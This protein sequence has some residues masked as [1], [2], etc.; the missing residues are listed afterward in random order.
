MA[1]KAKKRSVKKSLQKKE[2]KEKKAKTEDTKELNGILKSPLIVVGKLDLKNT[3]C[4]TLLVS[5]FKNKA[6]LDSVVS[7]IDSEFGSIISSCLKDGYFNGEKDE[8]KTLYKGNVKLSLLGLGEE[9]K[10]TLEAMTDSTACALRKLRDAGFKRIGIALD[11]FPLGKFNDEIGIE[12]LT[13]AAL[14]GL[15]NFIDFKTKNREKIKYVEKV[16]LFSDKY[17]RYK[18]VADNVK[19]IAEAVNKTRDL[20]NTPPNIANPDYV[21]NYCSEMARNSRLKCRVLNEN[22]LKKQNMNLMLAVAE[23]SA[24]KPRLVIMEYNGGGNKGPIVLVG[25]GI[26]FDSGGLNV[27]QHPYIQNMKDDKAGA[28]AVIHVIEAAAKLKLQ[29]NVV[30]IAGLCENMISGTSYRPDDVITS[31][32]GLTVE[33]KN[34]DAEGR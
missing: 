31:H 32:S 1:K 30:A 12:K 34:T 20:I 17:Q 21:A 13:I 4:D 5:L 19:I 18:V 28:C 8:V 16:A 33:V 2:Q 26:T 9:N 29:V 25:K 24:N 6:K 27:K 3:E 23:G 7:K 11:S 10:L 14:L 15:Y 22:D